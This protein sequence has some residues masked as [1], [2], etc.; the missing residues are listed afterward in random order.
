MAPGE[1]LPLWG[2]IPRSILPAPGKISPEQRYK[3]VFHKM[4]CGTRVAI[5]E[6]SIKRDPDPSFWVL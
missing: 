6:W 2:M 1:I 5:E 4:S 3:S